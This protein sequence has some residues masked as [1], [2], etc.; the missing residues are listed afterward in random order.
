MSVDN[1]MIKSEM[2]NLYILI[3]GK[4]STGGNIALLNLDYKLTVIIYNLHFIRKGV[5]NLF[6]AGTT[7]PSSAIGV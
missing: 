3:R 2:G 1:D 7:A 4:T 6:L 5:T